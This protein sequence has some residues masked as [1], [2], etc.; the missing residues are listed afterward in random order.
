[1]GSFGS[2]L[3]QE[4]VSHKLTQRALAE[5]GGVQPNAQ[6]HYESGLRL[7]KVDYL[8]AI[9]EL[10]DVA[11]LITSERCVTDPSDLTHNEQSIVATLR[12]MTREDR[13]GVNQLFVVLGRHIR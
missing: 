8:L 9:S 5:L 10:I 3:R 7:P 13:A 2:R 12:R 11:Y 6:G 4:R 1:M